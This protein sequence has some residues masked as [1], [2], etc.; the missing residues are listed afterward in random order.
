MVA[1][2]APPHQQPRLQRSLSQKKRDQAAA[3]KEYNNEWQTGLCNAPCASPGYCCY[4]LFCPSC[5]AYSQ[6][7]LQMGA[8]WP[9]QYTCCNGMTCISGKCGERS[10]PEL[11]LACEVCCCFPNAVVTTRFMVQDEQ[12]VM[13]TQCDNCLIGFML[14]TQQLAACLRCI[15]IISQNP[16]IEQLADIVDCIADFTYATVCACM[17]TQQQVQIQYRDSNRSGGMVYPG[18]MSAPTAPTMQAG[19]PS[20]RVTPSVLVTGGQQPPPPPTTVVY[21]TAPPQQQPRR[22]A[23]QPTQGSTYYPP[24]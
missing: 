19:M 2:Y 8:A 24:M 13:N 23:A 7:V 15:A 21:M 11:C 16:D 4:A 5:A 9:S 1:M 20:S 3:R 17:Q 12:R 6:R 14:I 22:A 18:V 10:N